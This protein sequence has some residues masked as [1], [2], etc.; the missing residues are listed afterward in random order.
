MIERQVTIISK[1]RKAIRKFF[2]SLII[3]VAIALIAILAIPAGVFL[4]M[5]ACVWI[6]T[7]RILR[8]FD[9]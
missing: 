9:P 1:R 2:C 6:I 7:D 8:S 5:I 3:G 4:G